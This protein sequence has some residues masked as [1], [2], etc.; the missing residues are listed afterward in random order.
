MAG[1]CKNR[2][3]EC[4]IAIRTAQAHTGASCIAG[5]IS[6]HVR[7]QAPAGDQCLTVRTHSICWQGSSD[8]SPSR[9]L[10][11]EDCVLVFLRESTAYCGKNQTVRL[12][13]LTSGAANAAPRKVLD[14]PLAGRSK[15]IAGRL[16]QLG[17]CFQELK[18]DC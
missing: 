12:W 10:S 11:K 6:P 13:H 2:I 17:T 7:F 14:L 16:S 15:S 8:S 9:C 1:R 18:I 4:H 3:D 5:G